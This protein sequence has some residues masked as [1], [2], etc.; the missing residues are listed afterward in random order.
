MRVHQGGAGNQ[1]GGSH[2]VAGQTEVEVAALVGDDVRRPDQPL[3]LHQHDL[4]QR[5][6][7]MNHAAG[8]VIQRTGERLVRPDRAGDRGRLAVS[9]G[10]D[11]R[12][13]LAVLVQDQNAVPGTVQRDDIDVIAMS[14]FTSDIQDQVDH[15]FGLDRHDIADGPG[16]HAGDQVERPFVLVI[17]HGFRGR[18]AC[19]ENENC[20]M[21]HSLNISR[22]GLLK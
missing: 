17:D 21:L 14:R 20:H 7:G 13:G 16:I 15:R 6:H 2:Q 11:A 22:K 3:L 18:S 8:F 4:V 10:H 1:T 19:F 12:F 9:P 5:I